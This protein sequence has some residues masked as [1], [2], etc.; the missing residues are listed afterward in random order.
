MAQLI[1]K[2]VQCV[3]RPI[4]SQVFGSEKPCFSTDFSVPVILPI[5]VAHL[6][7]LVS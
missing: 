1:I 2:E 4:F 3:D 5:V 6:E 7:E